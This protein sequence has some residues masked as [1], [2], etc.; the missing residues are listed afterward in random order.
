MNSNRRGGSHGHLQRNAP[1]AGSFTLA[2]I[3]C[4]GRSGRTVFR[5][6]EH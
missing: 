6:M 1:N 3:E 4:I 2:E 5:A